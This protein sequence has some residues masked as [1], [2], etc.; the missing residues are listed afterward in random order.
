VPTSDVSFKN[1]TPEELSGKLGGGQEPFLLD[2][3]EPF[4]LIAF[5]A[6]PGVINIPVGQVMNRMSELPSGRDIVVVCQSGSRSL[7]VANLLSRSGFGS[8]FN[9]QGGTSRWVRS[10]YPISHPSRPVKVQPRA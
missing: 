3:R 6:I 2:V 7:E 9:L 1:I 8:V 4:E 5:G 10:G